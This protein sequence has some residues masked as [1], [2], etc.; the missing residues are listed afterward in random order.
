VKANVI[1]ETTEADNPRSQREE[2]A[3]LAPRCSA[4]GSRHE[5]IN[6]FL[7]GSATKP[8]TPEDSAKAEELNK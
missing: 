1:R 4:F 6:G 5:K 3:P 8:A 2:L 7:D